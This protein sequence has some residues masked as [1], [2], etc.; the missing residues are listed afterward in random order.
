VPAAITTI[1]N[2][3]AGRVRR[4]LI[5]CFILAATVAVIPG[6]LLSVT[7]SGASSG[8]LVNV[9]GSGFSTTANQNLV[10]F[11]PTAG[12][13]PSTVSATTVV[14]VDATR[15]IRR[16]SVRVPAGLP[17]GTVTVT[18][19]NTATGEASTTATFDLVTI[20][21]PDVGSGIIGA[22]GV[23]V[24]ITGSAA[25]KFAGT[26]P[27]VTF[28]AGVT[29]VSTTV[30]SAT[31]LVATINIAATA[32]AGARAVSIT[33]SV[34][35]LLLTDGFQV[36]TAPPPNRPPLANAHGPYAGGVNDAI[37]FSSAGSSDPDGDTLT[38]SWAFGDGGTSSDP[39]PLHQYVTPGTYTVALT[40][41][42]GK[43]GTNT[44]TTGA[45]INQPNRSPQITSSPVLSGR[46]GEPYS[47]QLVATDPDADPL[48]FALV[49]GP[50]GLSVSTSGLVAWTP[51]PTDVGSRDV[52]VQVSDGRGGVGTQAYS[53]AVGAAVSL[54]RIELL[55]PS[56]RFSEAGASSQL[57]VTGNRSDQS[58]I[59]LTGSGT[60]TAYESSDSAVASVSA[61]GLVRAIGNGSATITARNGGFSDTSTATVEIGVLLESLDLTPAIITLRTLSA[62]AST[63]LRGS[64]SDGSVRDLT[65]A[66]G[67]T[68][69]VDLGTVASTDALG[70]VT[71]V[72]PG[73]A[74]LTA[75][76][77]GRS[78]TAQIR[79]A[80]A[81]GTAFLRGEVFDDRRG[82]P[83][84]GATATALPSG[85]GAVPQSVA[86][87]DRGRFVAAS[88]AGP[89]V[90]RIERSGFTS[91]DR[92]AAPLENAVTTL[93]D[94]RLTPLDGRLNVLQS[95][96]GGQAASADGTATVVIPPGSLDGDAS[97]R[98]TP[99]SNQGLHGL[100][101]IGWSPIAAVDI[102]PAGRQLAQA[103]TLRVPHVDTLAAGATIAV[104]RYDAANRRWVVQTAGQVSGDR[105]ALTTEINQTGQFAFIV[106]DEAP[107]TPPAAIPGEALVGL[108]VPVV[109]DAS[110]A[111]G[112]V[113]P[114]SAAPGDDVR[115]I[116]TVVLQPAVPL[117][118][119]AI[120]RAR[121]QEQF[122][123]LDASRVRPLPFVQ[124][125]VVYSRPRLGAAGTLA[126]RLP[127]TPT[128]QFSIQQLSL[129]QV[130]LD[131]TIDEPV[132]QNAILG[133]GGG[134]VTD[135]AGDALEVPAGALPVDVAVGLLALGPGQLSIPVPDGFSSLA[136]VL[137][138]LVG[139]TFAQPA[140]LSITRPSG[141]DASK[142]VLVAQVITDLTGGRRLKIVGLGQVAGTRMGVQTVLGTLAFDGVRSGGEYV[143]LQPQLPVGF[144]TGVVNSP[145]GA[146][147]VLALVSSNTEPFVSVTGPT[148]TF[149]VAG[150]A[151]AATIVGALD[152]I[153]A[154]A[155]SA[156]SL[157]AA[158]DI[159]SLIL[160]LTTTAPA[161]VAV[162]P[163]ANATNVALDTS[164]IVDFSKPIDAAS[165]S[166][167]AVTVR[168]GQTAI[169]I[170]TVVSANRRRLTISP[171]S[172]LTGL[173]AYTL[174]LTSEIRD[175]AGAPL[176]A[177]N[178]VT[179]TTLDPSKPAALALGTITAELPD[180]GGLSLI[181]GASGAAD[182]GA[183][184]VATN[185]RTQET[186]TVIAL[187]DG[188]FRIRLKVVIGD[189]IAITF[190]DAK[191]RETT[192]SISQFAAADGTTSVGEAGGTI[193]DT[194]GR[195]GRVLPRALS[196]AGLF[197]L[198]VTGDGGLP[199][200]PGPLALADHFAL[201]I[202]GASFRRLDSLTLTDSQSRFSP[203]TALSAP[204][205]TSAQLTVPPDF[206]VSAS[207]RFT[208]TVADRDGV[209]RSATVATTV[210]GSG[211][212]TSD[213]EAGFGEQFPTV[214]VAAPKQAIP[215]QVLTVSAIAPTARIEF[216]LPS[217]TPADGNLLILGR[218]VTVSGEVKLVAVDR[219]ARVDVGG[220]SRLRTIGREFPGAVAGGDYAVVSGPMAI[221]S[222][223]VSG[224][225]AIVSIDGWPLV[226]ET[227]GANGSFVIPVLANAP[228]MLRFANAATGDTLGTA[229]GP[230]LSS[231]ATL[232]LGQP[233]AA[234]TGILLVSAQPDS[235]SVVDIGAP[236][237]FTFS[238]PLDRAS[239][240]ASAFVI[241]DDA[242]I[243][244]FGSISI[245]DDSRTVTFV[246]LRR[247]RFASHY[248]YGVTEA[249]AAASGARLAQPLFGEFTT[250]A[251]RVVGSLAIGEVRD[252]AVSG[253]LAVAATDSGFAVVQ[254]AKPSAPAPITSVSLVGGAR[255]VALL[256]APLVDRNGQPTASP[257][258]LV[259][260]GSAATSGSIQSFSLAAAAS[261]QRLGSTQVTIAPGEAP[262]AGVPAASGVPNA[263]A[264]DPQGNAFVSVR[265]V[266]VAS[267]ALGAAIP[268]DL[269]NPG[270]ALR[271]R[272]PALGVTDATQSAIVGDRVVVAE[273]SGLAVLA[274]ATL[275]P[276]ATLPIPGGLES[277]AA[278]PQYAFDVNGDGLI[279]ATE[280]FD[281]AVAGDATGIVQVYR[282]GAGTPELLSAIRLPAGARVGGIALSADEGLAYVGAG[283][284]GLAVIDLR[285]P[286]SVQ[287]ID[288]NSEGL[289]DRILGLLS[290]PGTSGRVASAL[291][292]G[293]VAVAGGAAGLETVQVLPPRTRFTSIKRD[294]I[295]GSAGDDQEISGSN[296]AFTTDRA[297]LLQI[298]AAIPDDDAVTLSVEEVTAGPRTTSFQGL[299]AIALNS[300]LNQVV[301][302]V[303]PGGSG[304]QVAF[305]ARNGAGA[306]LARRVVDLIPPPGGL[307]FVSLFAMP[308]AVTLDDATPQAEIVVG[309]QLADG[310]VLNVTRAADGSRYHSSQTV[311]VTVNG[312]GVVTAAGGGRAAID[313]ANGPRLASVVVQVAKPP[314]LIALSPVSSLTTLLT[315]ESVTLPFVGVFSDGSSAA[316]SDI[317]GTSF[318][319][320]DPAIASVDGS[321]RVTP[322]ANGVTTVRATNGGLTASFEVAVE[323][324]G[325][326]S[327]TAL[328]LAPFAAG[329][330]PQDGSVP[331]LATA[332]GDG[333]LHGLVVTFTYAGRASRGV[334]DRD[335][336]VAATLTGLTTPGLV[337]VTASVQD[338]ATGQLRTDA[339][340]LTVL[341]VDGDV[342]PNGTTESAVA[343]SGGSTVQGSLTTASDALDTFRIDS[344]TGGVLQVDLSALSGS[345]LSDLVVVVRD[346][347][348]NELSRVVPTDAGVV[349]QIPDGGAFITIQLTGQAAAYSLRTRVEQAP[350]TITAVAPST[351][352]AGTS[353]VITGTG[354]SAQLFQN[355]VMFGS[356]R[357]KLVSATPT[358]LDVV[359]PV[360]AVDGD[361]SII[362]DGR[363]VTGPRFV[364]GNA[365]PRVA[366]FALPSNPA[367][368]RYDP[369]SGAIVDVA[370]LSV[371]IDPTIGRA[372]VEALAT[373]VGA[374][375]AGMVP[376]LNRYVFERLANSTLADLRAFEL[377]VAALPGILRVS[378][379][380]RPRLQTTIDA[381]D[382]AGLWPTNT[383][384]RNAPFE[385]VKLF[386]AI[387]LVRRTEP[388]RNPDN[389]RPIRVAVI[390]SGFGPKLASEFPGTVT[391]RTR[392]ATGVLHTPPGTPTDAFGGH[393]TKATGIIAAANDG[394]PTADGT[395]T[396]GVLGSLFRQDELAFRASKVQLV[397][398]GCAD[399]PDPNGEIS[400][401]NIC[402]Q[403]ALD[404][405]IARGDVDV[406]NMSFRSKD[407]AVALAESGCPNGGTRYAG[408]KKRCDY[409]WLFQPLL[410]RTLLVAAAGNDGII[411]SNTFPAS[412]ESDLDNV[413]SVGA[414]AVADVD[415]SHEGPDERARF[416]GDSRTE[417][418]HAAEVDCRAPGI[419]LVPIKASNCGTGVT[420]AAPGEDFYTTTSAGESDQFGYFN[421]TSSAAPLVAGVAAMLQAIRPDAAIIPPARLREILVESAD[422]ISSKWRTFFNEPMFR[423]NALTAVAEVVPSVA[424]QHILVTDR[425]EN[426]PTGA[427]VAMSID[428]LT[429]QLNGASREIPLQLTKDGSTIKGLRPTAIV[430]GGPGGF[431]AFVLS[432]TDHPSGDAVFVLNTSA[433]VVD[434][435][436]FLNG[437]P[438][439][440]SG[441]SRP[442]VRSTLRSAMV[443]SANGRVLYVSA[444]SRVI[445]ID[446]VLYKAVT[447][448]DQFLFPDTYARPIPFAPISTSVTN[449]IEANA[450]E[451]TGL[452]ISPDGRS[453]YVVASNGV[454]SGSQ[455]GFLLELDIA[456]DRDRNPATPKVELD[457]DDYFRVKNSTSAFRGTDEPGGV[458]AA[459]DGKHVYMTNGGV[460]SFVSV[461]PGLGAALL[462][463]L[464][465]VAAGFF[466]SFIDITVADLAG[467]FGYTQ[468]LASGQTQTF[469]VNLGQIGSQ[470]WNF[471]SE[472]AQS[473]SPDAPRISD[474]FIRP[475]INSERPFGMAFRFD[476]RRALVPF[477]QTGN[478]GVLDL[479]GQTFQPQVA[480][481][482]VFQG[483]VAVTPSLKLDASLWPE[484]AAQESSLYPTRVTY[485][486]NGRFAAA[487]HT[488]VHGGAV[489]V[490]DDDKISS[491]LAAH[492]TSPAVPE[493]NPPGD[494]VPYFAVRPL[495]ATR[496]DPSSFSC[497]TD[498]FTT[499]TEYSTG[500]GLRTLQ[501]PRGVAIQP[502]VSVLGR[503]FGD[504]TSLG[505]GIVFMWRDLRASTARVEAWDLGPAETMQPTATPVGQPITR[506]LDDVERASRRIGVSLGDFFPGFSFPT[507]GTRFRIKVTILAGDGKEIGHEQVE[508]VY[509][510]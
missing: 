241:T 74:T 469:D 287:P 425:N 462:S 481:A 127:I 48:T 64:F 330:V 146:P 190:R 42:D 453:L 473:W 461:V 31:S 172:A 394:G 88:A 286:A 152:A 129:G 166:A 368:A 231:G 58:T 149:V 370:R 448:V 84:A 460:D 403:N 134:T 59:N 360:N 227:D 290:M 471:P 316:A 456:L 278:L 358:R 476:G 336:R 260:S 423:L 365:G 480:P 295:P 390:D 493:P 168:A 434:D 104:A 21:L 211:P 388:F 302:S 367:K 205:A 223:R 452:D 212:D 406:V 354:F 94:A 292:R 299:A 298:D 99:L 19:L 10:T 5:L 30:E 296:Q 326:S 65:N 510:Q 128:L 98:V 32:A 342:E 183:V 89:T 349:I 46:E 109:P 224:P 67:T 304:S 459:P 189:Q 174:A 426:N 266:G 332:S 500:E 148:G 300:G 442:A 282:L 105:R 435:V 191:G 16:L 118:S 263:I 9:T 303:V 230:G 400:I 422:D 96:F 277:I 73:T 122:D 245:S 441:A 13:A 488:G 454:G 218:T 375:V 321:G 450:Q 187:A 467:R 283:G 334:T 45:D 29:V 350:V 117:P 195:T 156:A 40:V 267:V 255:G 479:V 130:S 192:L 145:S 333:A 229:A 70:V 240:T 443:L 115:A 495:C 201:S 204:F 20:A 68:F 243:R 401:D 186:A 497:A 485:A 43:G 301:A 281:L 69:S 447:N 492:L 175:E 199:S 23:P 209:R 25:A 57:T 261:P 391:F 78:A 487:V 257:V 53:I 362:V 226:A 61:E 247:W 249:V 494:L 196:T 279:G 47:Y 389:V 33:S 424:F 264:V 181:T 116:G 253:G 37:A 259:A 329:T 161:V 355:A 238:E 417:D 177:F 80:L 306:V 328:A 285:G 251:P 200:L 503:G 244:S 35:S 324:R 185:L 44:A 408:A 383:A 26:S 159:A 464:S 262:P 220:T 284:R 207:L 399:P 119:G 377:A 436:I 438:F 364:V 15:G 386:D 475:H 270:G 466:P 311:V 395:Q 150:R 288:S 28:G 356:V 297:L 63:T 158:N 248:R 36:A 225:A 419:I 366:G 50:E 271:F 507:D 322:I 51:G 343:L 440:A 142:Q 86:A 141:F 272:F 178:P 71:A 233:L 90:V 106:P 359:V 155:S 4:F 323:L 135:T 110:T 378:P 75:R 153:G 2:T 385:L 234:T 276:M 121:V 413:V 371:D 427:V 346:S 170:Q 139:T 160:S 265:D 458:A 490:L 222:G 49:S 93:L 411:A 79:V 179:F 432:T 164:I 373:G 345:S 398:Y 415:S 216:D 307:E 167:S 404:E 133:A 125:L 27:R 478:F 143:F 14:T 210:V 92:A 55:P 214:F 206:L 131:V 6:T 103:A 203:G 352:S 208:A 430:T 38:F 309:G 100:L 91:V 410:G 193:T 101:P 463:Q 254:L 339:K 446:T 72:G 280:V 60:G 62:T 504:R 451:I 113:V 97:L 335:G 182:A 312:D 327:V 433:L 474:Q 176:A 357:G 123:L 242:G 124:D 137:V 320:S 258:A 274:R 18:V 338:P 82:I 457:V 162:S 132:V 420:L 56:L 347:A 165:I 317:A 22:Q 379:V 83:L 275:A 120:L 491:D 1:R 221:V 444:G 455:R 486:Q 3:R 12:G 449:L 163:A 409:F 219:L 85:A 136:A 506:L 313:I 250:F 470:I 380:D 363:S 293:I 337:Q 111:S 138:D 331:V 41:S 140:S 7:P 95:V 294:P 237:V 39:N 502:F 108:A 180:E 291:S 215:T 439:P 361:L 431:V 305:V 232:D 483:L 393:G 437:D 87:D 319:S 217:S 213:L 445:V 351:G 273:A 198:S 112:Q 268:L 318:S 173:T 169:A 102:Q 340:T 416:G 228:F 472:L 52:Q 484:S 396:S 407:Y 397:A 147:Q 236:L 421:G 428:P 114:R 369:L 468:L 194:G 348:G 414:V 314:A 384:A 252:V 235:Q 482:E 269:G 465:V 496:P 405:I 77:E 508:L 382:N 151:G 81:A 374:R 501:R 310:R 171:S 353:V 381:R 499:F 126:T 239:V 157:A 372:A 154:S 325:A 498:V 34:Q 315:T 376:S 509:R 412:L 107:F 202:D 489:T 341:P 402:I 308:A 188:S 66:A 387:E 197:Q 392:D 429:G 256:D 144:V 184:V 8:V 17:P 54:T 344:T 505:F 418:V 11:T 246:P 24:R 76:H 289:D 477:F